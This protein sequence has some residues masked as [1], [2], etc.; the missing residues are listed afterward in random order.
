LLIVHDCVLGFVYFASYTYFTSTYFPNMPNAGKCA[1][2]EFAAFSGLII[3]SS[4]LLL[5]ISFYLAT[6]KKTGKGGRPR[7]NTGRKAAIAMKNLELPGVGAASP[8]T[9]KQNGDVRSNGSAANG[10]A[11]GSATSSARS[12]GPVTRSRKA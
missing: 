4:Y 7:S 11:N 8:A 12:N 3:L 6:Y 10:S 2:E 9:G 5:F 1:G